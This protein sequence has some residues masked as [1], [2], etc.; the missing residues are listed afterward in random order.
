MQTAQIAGRELRRAQSAD[1]VGALLAQLQ[2]VSDQAQE[3]VIALQLLASTDKT[4]K[5]L[6]HINGLTLD[7]TALRDIGAQQT[8]ILSL[9]KKLDE[10]EIYWTR[11]FHQ[12][13]NSDAFALMPNVTLVETLI[14]EA[15]SA[16]KDARTAT[17]RYFVLSEPSQVARIT[18]AAD[19]AVEKLTMP[20]AMCATP[21]SLRASSNCARSFPSMS[22]L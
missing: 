13:V 4:R 11:A 14:N 17:W 8:L 21:R 5:Q 7:M 6:E 3:K 10:A 19:Q 18:G 16:F 9:F 15:G 22:A 12:L 20:A 1:Q 2:R